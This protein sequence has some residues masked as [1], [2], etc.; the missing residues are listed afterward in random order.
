MGLRNAVGVTAPLAAGAAVGALPLGLSM[1]AGA[2]NV[3]FSDSSVPYLQRAK[4]MLAASVVV[5]LGVSVGSTCGS[6]GALTLV[7]A[8][9]W[10]FAAGMLVALDQTAADL[11]LISLL[12]LLVFAG[13]PLPFDQALIAGT[14]A[15]CGGVLQTALAVASW[16]L[17]R[18]APERRALAD[19]FRELAASASSAPSAT[20]APPATAQ[21]TYAQD[22]L[23]TLDRD[24]SLEAERY[25]AL[26][27]QAERMRLGLLVLSR[28]RTRME[29]ENPGSRGVAAID[30][31]CAAASGVLAR[32]AR[33]LEMGSPPAGTDEM[34]ILRAK[35]QAL[36]EC[37]GQTARDARRQLDALTGQ[38]RAALDL[39]GRAVPEGAARFERREAEQSW[40]LRLSGTLAILRANL[41][42][43]SAACRHAVR[44]AVCIAIG[45]AM[46][47][48]LGLTRSYWAPMTIGIVLKP[49]FGTTFSRG[50]L[51]FAGTFTGLLIATALFHLVPQGTGLEI[52]LVGVFLFLARCYGPANYGIAAT[53]I[54]A[55]VVLLMALHGLAPNSVIAPRALNTL[56][57]GV[58]ALVAYSI[59][60]TWERTQ[61]GET[62]ARMF[63][64]Y[65]VYFAAVRRAY[66]NPN[67]DAF[68]ELDRARVAGRRARTNLEAS[69][70][71]LST[72]P[73]TPP[74]RMR[75]LGAML[76]NSH[77][78]VHAMMALEAGLSVSP[79]T[80]AREEFRIFANDVEATLQQLAEAFRTGCLDVPSL[81]D[82]R[83][84]HERLIRAGESA[85]ARHALVNVE[86]DRIANS[87]N[88][89]AE[90]VTRWLA[91]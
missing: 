15:F 35:E 20:Q 67:A 3:A 53:A 91:C 68:P 43:Q 85:N 21:S 18:Y 38:F 13:V 75:L 84:D 14:L 1:A 17:R 23:A 48:T 76:A 86:T 83:E 71:R 10:A 8:A 47:Q 72:E 87:L 26:L 88:T 44:L 73:G 2:M 4:R 60:P 46:G 56:A 19:L 33:G 16:P 7:V 58:V 61:L 50:V 81:P 74:E 80:P 82:L 31:F 24:R 11:G 66:E 69:V 54:T 63:D 51:R 6:N 52:A 79:S 59:W 9:G 34:E 36:R 42:L 62:V 45:E 77:R 64:A 12:T 49:D 78:L 41:S 65:R 89:L 90:D 29:R 37:T 40:R 25:R 22:T 32:I 70:D 28:L 30:D 57:G 39:A 5:G 27:S 55:L